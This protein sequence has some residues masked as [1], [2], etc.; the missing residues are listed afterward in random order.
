[1][2]SSTI[3]SVSNNDITIAP[4]GTGLLILN[5]SGNASFSV[6]IRGTPLTTLDV[7]GTT[8][9]ERLIANPT[10]DGVAPTVTLGAVGQVG[11]GA[12]S[13]IVGGLLAGRFILTTGTGVLTTGL[14]ATFD[15]AAAMP[16][17]PSSFA[18]IMTSA[19][20]N[21]TNI[22]ARSLTAS[23]FTLT[24]TGATGLAASAV[25]AWNYV[26]IGYG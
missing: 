5:Q 1:M 22:E 13:V 12:T 17:S 3:A 23:Q 26:V 15:L 6:G 24:S 16:F 8:R 21:V 20:G 11:T 19:V 7:Y 4:N 18:V 2:S 25:Y 14:L 9:I 10:G